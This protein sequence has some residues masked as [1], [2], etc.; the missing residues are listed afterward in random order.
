MDRACSTHW[1]E[2]ECIQGFYGKVR[3]K[4]TVERPGIIIIKWI[5]EKYDEVVRRGL[6]WPRIGTSGGLL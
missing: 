3:R 6:I 5:L 1:V 4:E 2:E